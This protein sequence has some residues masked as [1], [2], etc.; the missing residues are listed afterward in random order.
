MNK[1]FLNFPIGIVIVSVLF[2]IFIVSGLWQRLHDS[3]TE[4]IQ[5]TMIITPQEA[6]S[7]LDV[8][9]IGQMSWDDSLTTIIPMEDGEIVI[10]VL[11]RESE[12]GLA[13]EQFIAFINV[14]SADRKVNLTYIGY[15]ERSGRYRRMWTEPTA[16]TRPDTISLF[17]LD[18]V[19][20][21]SS[22]IIVTGMNNRNEHTMTIFRKNPSSPVNQIFDKIAE[23]QIDGSIVIQETGRSLA[24]QQGITAGQSF[25]IAA[26][27]PDITSSNI[28][29]QI[30]TI[31]SFNLST[32][33]YEQSSISR[34][35]G[36]Q[37]EQRRI[38]ELLSGAPGVFENYIHDLWYFVSPQ[39]TIDSRQYIYLDPFAREIIFYGDETQQ[40]FHWLNST[41]T[42]YGLFITSQNISIS[43]LRRRIDIELESLDSIRLRVSEDV[44]IR[45]DITESWDGSYRRAGTVNLKEAETSVRA[46]IDATYDSTWG[47]LQFNNS[48]EYTIN[49]GNITRKG[50][51]VFYKVNEHDLLEMRPTDLDSSDINRTESRMVYR[52][53]ATG[54]N[55]IILS[56]VRIGTGGIQELFEPPVILTLVE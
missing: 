55:S 5:G 31:Y 33:E 45:I 2:I 12:E 10:A 49:S 32:G 26:Y 43:T 17:N 11:D 29:D 13:L 16:A 6:N 4:V 24:Y 42:R 44:R 41:P 53:S 30:E 46:A 50:Y 27:G 18:L 56:R 19:G 48:G 22:C 54:N 37:V 25:N 28:L 20:D 35:P 47:K 40:V 34:I 7:F 1:S 14:S 51:Y 23:I 15:D 36:S 38:R 21:R 52:I 8:N 39:G 3:K 9:Y